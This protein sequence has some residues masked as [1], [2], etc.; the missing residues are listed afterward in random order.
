MQIYSKKMI[1]KLRIIVKLIVVIG[2]VTSLCSCQKA[3]ECFNYFSLINEKT[4]V[5]DTI[6]LTEELFEVEYAKTGK[7]E[8]NKIN[9]FLYP[10]DFF[11]FNCGSHNKCRVAF[12]RAT[13]KLRYKL[14]EPFIQYEDCKY[15]VTCYLYNEWNLFS[16]KVVLNYDLN[17]ETDNIIEIYLRN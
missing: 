7:I 1:E 17:S 9:K 11:G 16:K 4:K 10:E 6:K 8:S 14:G 13:N 15:S 2:I 5:A 3:R 12:M